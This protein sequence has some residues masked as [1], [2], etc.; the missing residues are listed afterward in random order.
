MRAHGISLVTGV[1][2]AL[3]PDLAAQPLYTYRPELQVTPANTWPIE[4]PA[5][6]DGRIHESRTYFLEL[7]VMLFGCLVRFR[8]LMVPIFGLYVFQA[9]CK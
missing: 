1:C 5:M 4:H 2:M 9:F 6:C 8:P 7:Y 3:S